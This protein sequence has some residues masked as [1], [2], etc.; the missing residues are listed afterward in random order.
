MKTDEIYIR[1][2]P[3]HEAELKLK[4]ELDR[5]YMNQQRRVRIIHGKGQGVLKKLVLDYASRQPFV[6]KV[7]DAPFYLGGSGV[8]IVEFD[9]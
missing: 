4:K 8:T 1:R 2:L 6:K 9:L 3:F 7:S 5:C